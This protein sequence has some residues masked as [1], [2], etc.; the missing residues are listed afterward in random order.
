MR[1]A[2]VCG[3]DFSPVLFGK[4]GEYDIVIAADS[5]CA[6]LASMGEAPDE[7]IGDFDS[8]G[9][10]PEGATVLPVRKDDT[11]LMAAAKLA[12]GKG[13]DE[14]YIFGALG[15]KRFSHSVA[16]LQ[17]AGFLAE[18]G[19]RA[20]I[21]D[22][23]CTVTAVSRGSLVFP[24]GSG[25]TVS[26]LALS[27]PVTVTIKGLSYTLSRRVLTPLYPVGVSNEFTGEA[28]EITAEDG[29]VIVITEP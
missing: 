20:V 8:L 7:I 9:Y 14:I 3:G 10:V 21:R 26:V 25:G 18:K 22:S 1:A 16:A 4:C 2:I 23:R 19:V 28:A 15:G 6:A 13:A 27:G 24:E 12:V 17:T 29:T 11:D 5:G